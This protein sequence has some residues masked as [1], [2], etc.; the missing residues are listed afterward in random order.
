MSELEA[1]R[2]VIKTNIEERR[3]ARLRLEAALEQEA[4]RLRGVMSRSVKA[5][6]VWAGLV[7]G[8]VMVGVSQSQPTA[9]PRT[10][11]VQFHH[12]PLTTT[13]VVPQVIV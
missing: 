9:P 11:P 7:V 10:P 1:V 12:L 2:A 8:V 13:S 3:V 4:N 6:L 5:A